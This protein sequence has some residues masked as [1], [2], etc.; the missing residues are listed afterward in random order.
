MRSFVGTLLAAAALTACANREP[1][2]VDT[3]TRRLA[4]P[5]LAM[6]ATSRVVSSAGGA[7]ALEVTATLWNPS[8]SHILLA[9]GPE[10]PL[11]VWVFPDPTGEFMGSVDP[12]KGCASIGATRDVAPGD[13]IVLTRTVGADAF[14]SLA[15][16]TYGVNVAVTT[17]TAIMGG[18]GG[19]V[20]LPLTKAP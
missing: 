12:S 6:V 16:G 4:P 1:T 5:A 9:V 14:A 13:T 10:C 18:W 15:A 2:Q 11:V 17:N 19:A 7:P 3:T 20:H 8:T